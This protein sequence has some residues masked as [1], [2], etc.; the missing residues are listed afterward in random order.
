MRKIE[1]QKEIR[2]YPSNLTVV[3]HAAK[4]EDAG[5]ATCFDLD[6]DVSFYCENQ[7]ELSGF[8]SYEEAIQALREDEKEEITDKLNE[9]REMFEKS[10]QVTFDVDECHVDDILRAYIGYARVFWE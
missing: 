7:K 8:E 1:I 3:I 9:V 10:Y 4:E 5:I 6:L 2:N